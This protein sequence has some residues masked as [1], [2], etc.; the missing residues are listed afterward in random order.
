MPTLGEHWDLS[1]LFDS[2]SGELPVQALT[3]LEEAVVAV[4]SFRPRLSPD[5]PGS[6]WCDLLDALE[7]AAS[8]QRRLGGYAFL[9]FAENTSDQAALSQQNRVAQLL[10]TVENR[11]NFIEHWFKQLPDEA[12]RRLIDNAGDRRY[13]LETFRRFKPYTLSEAEEKIITLKDVNGVEALLSLYDIITNAFSYRLT[14]DGETKTLTQDEL[15]AHVRDSR[16]EIRAATYQEMYRVYMEHRTELAQIYANRVGDWRS[17]MIDLRGFPEPISATNTM[18][19]LPDQVVDTLLAVCRKN[20]PLYQRYFALKAKWLGVERLRRYDI[21]APLTQ[22]ID[23]YSLDEARDLVLECF[24]G[25]SSVLENAARRV[26]DSGHLDAW[27]RQGKRGGAFC[28]AC[29]P[30]LTPWVLTNFSGRARDVSTLAHELGHAIHAVLA[31]GH[32]VLSFDVTAPLAETASV[33]AE[34]LLSDKLQ[35]EE[36]N[37]ALRRDMLVTMI[38]DWYA[39]VMRQAFFVI[40]ERD[41]HRLVSQGRTSDEL[42]ELYLMNLREQ[43]GDSV[44]VADE[45]RWEWLIIQHIYHMPFYC[46]AYSFGLLLVLALYQRYRIEGEAFKPRYLKILSYGGSASPMAI[47]DEAGFDISTASFWQGGFDYLA[48]LIDQVEAMEGSGA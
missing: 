19:D 13:F 28:Y 14:I 16:P 31:S 10:A 40:F 15:T 18:N 24:S 23:R 35:A 43:F 41:A 9:R 11:L 8:L 3:D 33:F 32:S 20:A 22:S 46:Y 45:F 7:A 4:E 27:P 25:F 39:T 17:E 47:L 26:L 2:A 34:M 12:A 29:V 36:T 44:D 21:Y 42:A 37:P 30:E 38:D 5:I 6:D 1:E 48:S